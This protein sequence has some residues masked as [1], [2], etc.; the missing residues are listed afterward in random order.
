ML[1]LDA[2]MAN[3]CNAPDIELYAGNGLLQRASSSGEDT[4]VLMRCLLTLILWVGIGGSLGKSK[5]KGGDVEKQAQS[6]PDP[7]PRPN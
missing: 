4:G 2:N 5:A 1:H 7:D 6:A 3:L